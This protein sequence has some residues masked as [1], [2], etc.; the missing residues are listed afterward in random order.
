MIIYV[1][2]DACPRGIK[3][4]LYKA[5]HSRQ[6]MCIFVANQALTHPPSP[7][8][9]MRCVDKGFDVADDYIVNKVQNNDLVITADIPLAK[10]AID[11]G[12]LVITPHGKQ[13]TKANISQVFSMRNFFTELREAGLVETR[14]KPF[15]TQNNNAFSNALDQLLTKSLKN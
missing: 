3:D 15:S 5:A 11:N 14:T 12:A 6:V 7:Y 2:A 9:K 4:I 10:E 13:Y 1:D 8:I